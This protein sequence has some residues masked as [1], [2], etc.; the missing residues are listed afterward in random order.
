MRKEEEFIYCK[1]CKY[2]PKWKPRGKKLAIC[3]AYNK[4]HEL[5]FYSPE[6]IDIP[7]HYK[8]CNVQNTYND[9]YFYEDK[10]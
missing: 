3:K 8:F 7:T 2:F 6:Y 5:A 1:D 9:C 10:K 4:G